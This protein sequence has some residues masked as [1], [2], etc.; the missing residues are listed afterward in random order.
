MCGEKQKRIYLLEMVCVWPGRTE[1]VPIV[2]VGFFVARKKYMWKL[3]HM[4]RERKENISLRNGL[5]VWR[6]Q[7]REFIFALAP[8]ICDFSPSIC[9]FLLDFCVPP[10]PSDFCDF[11]RYFPDFSRDVCGVI[12][13]CGV[14]FNYF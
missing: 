6:E 12:F 14:I 8:A 5:Y 1:N 2:E 7:K 9:D 10:F 11:L 3:A 4:W 13:Y